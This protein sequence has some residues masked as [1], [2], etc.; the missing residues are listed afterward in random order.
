MDKIKV[1][2]CVLLV[3]GLADAAY[4]T[5]VHYQQAK[6]YC[7]EGSLINC[8]Q[9][10]TSSLSTVGGIP[11]SIGGIVWCLVLLLFVL[12][13]KDG[14]VRNIWLIFGLGAVLYSISG[15]IVIGKICVFCTLLDAI[16][17]I[18]V[19]LVLRLDKKMR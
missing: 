18:S 6:L 19:F 13:N 16:I 7:P 15:Q 2:L 10:V 5:M 12:F 17:L 1:L 8:E 9:V 14:V 11:I 4:L 3:A